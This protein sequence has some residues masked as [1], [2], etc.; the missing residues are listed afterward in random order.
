MKGDTDPLHLCLLLALSGHSRAPLLRPNLR[1][2]AL[3][4][5]YDFMSA[6]QGRWYGRHAAA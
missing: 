5:K 2:T 1:V 4:N 6:I 3:K